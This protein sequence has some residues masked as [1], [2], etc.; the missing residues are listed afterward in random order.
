[1]TE[2]LASEP[3]RTTASRG[4]ARAK[5][6]RSFISGAA[7]GV[8]SVTATENKWTKVELGRPTV[9]TGQA[10]MLAQTTAGEQRL[11]YHCRVESGPTHLWAQTRANRQEITKYS[12]M[13]CIP[14][15]LLI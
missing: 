3:L 13:P 8:G 9:G 14:N 12:L 5:K 1:M 2:T 10:E 4:E 11:Q 7:G 6:I 15:S